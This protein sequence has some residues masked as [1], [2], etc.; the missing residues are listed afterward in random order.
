[1]RSTSGRRFPPLSAASGHLAEFLS[2]L[3]ASSGYLDE[4]AHLEHDLRRLDGI[5]PALPGLLGRWRC[6]RPPRWWCWDLFRG[7]RPFAS[8]GPTGEPTYPSAPGPFPAAPGPCP[9]RASAMLPSFIRVTIRKSSLL[10]ERSPSFASRPGRSPC[11]RG[12]VRLRVWRKGYGRAV[13][14]RRCGGEKK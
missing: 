7:P 14:H 3:A 1:M 10:M 8:T 5:F 11:F 9:A 2:A 13:Q 4:A 6:S 12:R